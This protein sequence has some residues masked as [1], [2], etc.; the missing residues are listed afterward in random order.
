MWSI[1]PDLAACVIPE[2]DGKIYVCLDRVYKR[3]HIVCKR[4]VYMP[5]PR[6][7]GLHITGDRSNLKLNMVPARGSS[8]VLWRTHPEFGQV[9]GANPGAE[10]PGT[11]C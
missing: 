3:I 11:V 4:G 6:R 8:D 1:D 2:S 5:G 9:Q 10:T 7:S